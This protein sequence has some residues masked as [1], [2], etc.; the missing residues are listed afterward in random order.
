M[1]PEEKKA[2][3]AAA[4]ERWWDKRRADPTFCED[5]RAKQR[6]R[7]AIDPDPWKDASAR[8]VATRQTDEKARSEN[9]AYHREHYRKDPIYYRDNLLRRKY[10]MTP[11]ELLAILATQN[12]QCAICR[13]PIDEFTRRVD[14][15]H[16]SGAVRGLLCH[17]CNVALGHLK[18]SAE[19]I[20]KAASYLE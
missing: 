20:R 6:E 18:D 16:A 8:A 10:G 11:D 12:F 1:T 14:H 7:Y 2:R 9:A 5:Y 15:D 3:Q 4:Y 13:D 19:I 17:H